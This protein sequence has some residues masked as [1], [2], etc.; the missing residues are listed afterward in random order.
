MYPQMPK[1]S[2]LPRIQASKA[3]GS[4]LTPPFIS[5]VFVECLHECQHRDC[6]RG[7]DG[8]IWRVSQ[9]IVRNM[10]ERRTADVAQWVG[11]PGK[12]EAILPPLCGINLL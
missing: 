3:V 5:K 4:L 6:S 12:Q 10:K 2:R 9:P 7:W 8:S 1:S 11:L